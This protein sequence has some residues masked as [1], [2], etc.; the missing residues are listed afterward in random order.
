MNIFFRHRNADTQQAEMLI[1]IVYNITTGD[2]SLRDGPL[3][4]NTS[5]SYMIRSCLGVTTC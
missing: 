5:S 4:S 1:L 2:T 3:G